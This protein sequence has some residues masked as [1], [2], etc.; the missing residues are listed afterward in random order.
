MGWLNV[1]IS[2]I[3]TYLFW[4]TGSNLLMIISFLALIGVAWSYGIMHNFATRAATKRESYSG[5]FHDFSNK[6]MDSVP[7]WITSVNLIFSII[8]II[9]FVTSI[10]FLIRG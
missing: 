10:I 1:L 4:K 9:L 2:A 7:D 3:T 8:S 6:E 5:G